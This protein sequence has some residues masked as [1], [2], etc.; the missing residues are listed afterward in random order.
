MKKET[1]DTAK[2]TWLSYFNGKCLCEKCWKRLSYDQLKEGFCPHCCLIIGTYGGIGGPHG[3]HCR[4]LFPNSE[5][6]RDKFISRKNLRKAALD[7]ARLD[8]FIG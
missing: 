2:F 4:E 8:E 6:N 3:K 1:A 7:I 5:K